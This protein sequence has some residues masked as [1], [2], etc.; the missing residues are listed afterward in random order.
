MQ[1][2]V[3][4]QW[5]TLLCQMLPKVQSGLFLSDSAE[6]G[7]TTQPVTWPENSLPDQDVQSAVDM[8]RSGGASVVTSSVSKEGGPDSR[9][10]VACPLKWQ[11]C[12]LGVVGIAADVAPAQQA[13]VQQ[14]LQWGG[15]W[16]HLLQLGGSGF[17]DNTVLPV[18][19]DLLPVL[20][21]PDAE[22][23]A[24]TA[25]T[26]LARRLEC[27][28][29]S[30]GMLVNGQVQVLGL[31]NSTGFDARSNLILQIEGAMRETLGADSNLSA[32]SEDAAALPG[33]E[34]LGQ[35]AR[36]SGHRV[37]SY[38][39]LS[40]DAPVGVV[41]LE[42]N[43]P[44]PAALGDYAAGLVA[45]LGALLALKQQ[46]VSAASLPASRLGSALRTGDRRKQ[47]GI[48]AVIL[49]LLLFAA[50]ST[51][52]RVV[53]DAVLEGAVQR[54]IVAPFEGYIATSLHRAGEE[55]GEGD[56]LASLKDEDLRLEHRKWLSQREEL[57]REYRKALAVL[58]HSQARIFKSQVEQAEA[59]L[60]LL[61]YQLERVEL[62]APFDG[63]IIEGD[64]SQQLGVPVDR[65]QVLFQLAPLDQY[66]VVLAVDER[67]IPRISSGQ[68]GR[69]TLSAL[70]SMPLHFRVSGVSSVAAPQSGVNRFRVEADLLDSDS[71]Q[72]LRPGMQ[73]LGKVEIGDT[74]R[75]SGWSRRLLGWL[76]LQLWKWT[77]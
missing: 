20:E 17:G 42:R 70:P 67:D 35:L 5:L 43:T 32:T 46:Q 34:V 74:R 76:Q 22:I 29:V 44:L 56:V 63:V 47:I 68:T 72:S 71:L 54:A 58:N 61:D 1:H 65:G 57:Q 41:V 15:A 18:S 11:D 48:L 25:A 16:L 62:R 24:I 8:A 6:G 14:L 7:N 33:Q 37:Y 19:D 28:R 64:L 36:S 55:V 39:L 21:C 73:G 9:L 45:W 27:E 13:S 4:Q 69:L 12:S 30:I 53:A 60:E 26:A 10:I 75:I 66:R 2:R 59:E 77:P 3:L 31:S 23:A 40:K 38:Q 49:A 50:G 52:D 51:T